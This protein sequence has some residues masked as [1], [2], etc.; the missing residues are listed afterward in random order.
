[1]APAGQSKAMRWKW[2]LD[3]IV[4]I[5]VFYSREDLRSTVSDGRERLLYIPKTQQTQ[6]HP[7]LSGQA[8]AAPRGAQN[9]TLQLLAFRLSPFSSPRRRNSCANRPSRRHPS[10]A[11]PLGESSVKFEEM[12]GCGGFPNLSRLQAVNPG[13]RIGKVQSLNWAQK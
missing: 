5:F 1:M 2:V 10:R 9:D 4:R 8:C 12:P 13:A 7:D 6:L 3:K 11:P